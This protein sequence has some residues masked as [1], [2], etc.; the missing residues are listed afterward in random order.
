LMRARRADSLVRRVVVVIRI[1]ESLSQS[2]MAIAP[3]ALRQPPAIFKVRELPALLVLVTAL[4]WLFATKPAFRTPEN[5]KQVAQEAGLLGILACGEALVI[6]TGGIDLSVGA[7]AALAAVTAGP[8]MLHGTAWPLAM[9]LGLCAGAA[10]GWVN[11]ALITWR[12]LS[13]ILTTLATLFLFRALANIMTGGVPFTPL[14][15]AFGALGQGFAPFIG[16]VVVA[17]VLAAVLSRTRFGRRLVAVGGSEQA[18]R[19]SGVSTDAILRRVYVLCGLLAGLVGLLLAAGTRSAMWSIADGYELE[20]I[21][22][23]VIGGVRLTGGEGSVLGAAIGAMIIVVMRNA[24]FLGGVPYEQY[25][26]ITGSVI[27]LAA[28]AEQ[29]RRAREAKA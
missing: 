19:L 29:Y 25:G 15:D 9:G 17:V 8:R 20:A 22:A 26:L 24:L 2:T 28:F 21:A 18:V 27:L 10:A 3:V 1:A 14:P 12:K 7:V 11:A 13:P 5:L 6:L 23:V 4:V 16:L